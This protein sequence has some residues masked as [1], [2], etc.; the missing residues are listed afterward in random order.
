MFADKML[1]S[2]K[3]HVLPISGVFASQSVEVQIPGRP[4]QCVPRNWSWAANPTKRQIVA[5]TGPI[6]APLLPLHHH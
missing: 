1:G 3:P 5:V 4:N 2:Q 6:C